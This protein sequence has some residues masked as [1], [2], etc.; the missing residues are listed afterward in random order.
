MAARAT[1][2]QVV[3]SEES[4]LPDVAMKKFL[5]N[6]QLSGPCS[7]GTPSLFEPG[8]APTIRVS[9]PHYR[10]HVPDD[11]EFRIKN[12]DFL[13]SMAFDRYAGGPFHKF[14]KKMN[15][16]K[17]LYAYA[18]WHDTQTYLGT[19]SI[20]LQIQDNL[21]LHRAK[22]I[23][24]RYLMMESRL[25]AHEDKEKLRYL[26]MR[27]EADEVIRTAQDVVAKPL[28][29]LWRIFRNQDR[30]RFAVT[31]LI[32]RRHVSGSQSQ[33]VRLNTVIQHMF[34]E[35]AAKA[36]R[37]FP[38]QAE[39]RSSRALQMTQHMTDEPSPGLPVQPLCIN[40]LHW[41]GESDF[42]SLT[43]PELI[44]IHRIDLLEQLERQ[45]LRQQEKQ[46]QIKI[47]SMH[48]NMQEKA[49]VA[50][51]VTPKVPYYM[52]PFVKNRVMH[53]RTKPR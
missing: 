17:C 32:A 24:S 51:D 36:A 21:R 23:M 7:G 13:L 44:I 45:K 1:I 9:S 15:D 25:F 35:H 12:Q 22:I 2:P 18:F 42:G 14:I 34:T 19:Y 29:P 27:G 50:G 3:R 53:N 47:E 40:E 8:G 11:K 43:L 6:A 31:C 52:K 41:D 4:F 26:L 49:A 48:N 16:I 33:T 39:R 46:W 10:L 38:S 30:K 28:L 20:N 37:R 5:S